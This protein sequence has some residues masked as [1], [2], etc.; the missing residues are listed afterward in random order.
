[1]KRGGGCQSLKKFVSYYR[2]HKKLFFIDMACALV[3]SVCN[4]VYPS[5]AGSI[6]RSREIQTVLIGRGALLAI[7]ALKAALNYVI[8]Y[9]GHVVGVR[10]Q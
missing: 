8:A 10:I 4:L 1:M 5:I 6:V 9:W 2:P 3:V 7:F